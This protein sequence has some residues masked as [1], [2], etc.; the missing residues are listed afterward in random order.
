[1]LDRELRLAYEVLGVR[2][3]ASETEAR[4]ARLSLVRSFHP[5][6]YKGDRAAAD[7]KLARIN[8]AYDDVLAH[9]RATGRGQTAAQRKAAKEGARQAQERQ[10]AEEALR[11]RMRERN[12]QDA[13]RKE[14]RLKAARDEIENGLGRMAT[15]DRDAHLSAQRAF[16]RT[17]EMQSPRLARKVS[18]VA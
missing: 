8:A 14:A 10:R 6:T 3:D 13:A 1:M 18:R 16:S 12:A 11:V 4:A 15:A 7:R 2:P 9:I 17:Q 5:D